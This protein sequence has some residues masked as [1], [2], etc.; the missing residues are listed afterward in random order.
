MFSGMR[1]Y[2]K[3]FQAIA[4]TIGTKTEAHMRTFYINHRR[5]Y[6]L[7]T[8]LKEFEQEQGPIVENDIK[9]DKVD[10]VGSKH[11]PAFYATF[12]VNVSHSF[13]LINEKKSPFK[14]ET[15][16]LISRENLLL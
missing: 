1:K 11:L 9:E 13:V 10:K 7:D 16:L 14:L 15:S 4:E 3:D 8:V 5:R 2:G 6:N 12:F